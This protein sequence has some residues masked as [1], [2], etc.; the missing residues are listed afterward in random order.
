MVVAEALGSQRP[1][2]RTRESAFRVIPGHKFVV[3][4]P[5]YSENGKQRQMQWKRK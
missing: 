4:E 3:A 1:G 5:A 2:T